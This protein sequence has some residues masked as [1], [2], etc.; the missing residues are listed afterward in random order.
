MVKR[1][2]NQNKYPNLNPFAHLI[3]LTKSICCKA[4]TTRFFMLTVKMHFRLGITN[5][6]SRKKIHS[7]VRLIAPEF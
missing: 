4:S 6:M 5:K 2:E 7:E 1:A 3:S